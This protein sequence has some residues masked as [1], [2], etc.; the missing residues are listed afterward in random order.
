MEYVAWALSVIT[1]LFVGGFLKSY[2][3]K[4]GENLATKEDIAALTKI[5]KEIEHTVST[6]AWARDLRRKA[7]FDAMRKL[8]TLRTALQ[9]IEYTHLPNEKGFVTHPAE[10]T[11]ANKKFYSAYDD[12]VQAQM[13]TAIVCGKAI[14]TGLERLLFASVTMVNEFH[15]QAW[16]EA[17]Q[18]HRVFLDDIDALLLLIRADLGIESDKQNQ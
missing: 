14:D 9:E 8:G 13:I 4:K 16:A 11:E 5:T 10:Q 7:A 18:K 1:A 15:E 6:K 12:L 3:S 2:M 17:R